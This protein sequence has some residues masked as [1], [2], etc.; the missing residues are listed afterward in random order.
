MARNFSSGAHQQTSTVRQLKL[1]VVVLIVSNLGLGGFSFYL[2]RKTDRTYSGLIDQAV[3]VLNDLQALTASALDTMRATNG[4]LFGGTAEERTAAALRARR[5]IAEDLELRTKL[6]RTEWMGNGRIAQTELRSA[7]DQFSNAARELIGLL[8]AGRMA[9]ATR[10][11]E[12]ILRGRFE[13]YVAVI[14]KAADLVQDESL[15][16]SGNLTDRT[17]RMSNLVLGFGSWPVVLLGG[18]LVLTAGFVVV[19]MILFR[20]R[21]MNDVP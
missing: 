8:E 18:L 13:R 14:T 9:E 20:G 12:D 16:L 4:S 7:G 3:P 2:L 15:R 21:E 17:D 1:L 6:L 10:H 19:L 11:R 5:E